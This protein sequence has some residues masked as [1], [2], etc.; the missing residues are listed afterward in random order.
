MKA[1]KNPNRQSSFEKE[2]SWRHHTSG[3]KIHYKAK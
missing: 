1:K 3:F 2:Q